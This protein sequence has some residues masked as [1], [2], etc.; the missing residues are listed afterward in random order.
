MPVRPKPN[1]TVD[2][3]ALRNA[4]NPFR[5]WVNVDAKPN[6]AGQNLPTFEFPDVRLRGYVSIPCAR[7]AVLPKR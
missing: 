2:K 5:R 7:I 1:S 6:L 4:P 3:N